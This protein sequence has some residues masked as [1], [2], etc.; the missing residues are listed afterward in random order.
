MFDPIIDW[1]NSNYYLSNKMQICKLNKFIPA[2][3]SES[4]S[5]MDARSNP[6]NNG[7]LYSP[8]LLN[9][10]LIDFQ[11]D[12]STYITTTI[13]SDLATVDLALLP[14]VNKYYVY[15]LDGVKI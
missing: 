11:T 9:E 6:L 2:Y 3:F 1:D 8:Q 15:Y 5:A 10:N 14:Y 12:N 4:R 13:N 7:Y